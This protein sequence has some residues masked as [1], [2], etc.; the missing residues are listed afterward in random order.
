MLILT[1]TIG[2]SY[3]LFYKM[4]YCFGKADGIKWTKDVYDGKY[5]EQRD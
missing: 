1:I 4:G 5:D 2:I 3:F